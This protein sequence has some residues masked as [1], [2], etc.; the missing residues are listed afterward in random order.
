MRCKGSLFIKSLFHI[1]I[2]TF[3]YEYNY[4]LPIFVGTWNR[5]EWAAGP[6]FAGYQSII[7]LAGPEP[8]VREGKYKAAGTCRNVPDLAGKFKFILIIGI[9]SLSIIMLILIT[10]SSAFLR[11]I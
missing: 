8:V 2:E 3:E 7:R 11:A 4:K 6:D 1:D 9:L 5:P 10:I